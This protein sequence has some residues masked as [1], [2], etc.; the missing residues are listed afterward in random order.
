MRKMAVTSL[1]LAY[2]TCVALGIYEVTAKSPYLLGAPLP[3]WGTTRQVETSTPWTRPTGLLPLD[4][5]LHETREACRFY[6]LVA[7]Q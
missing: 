2:I 3:G 5:V 1:Y 4:K 6:I 7:S